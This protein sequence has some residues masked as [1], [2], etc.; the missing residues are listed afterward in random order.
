M[1]AGC[2]G[3]GYCGVGGADTIKHQQLTQQAKSWRA[4]VFVG[5]THELANLVVYVALR[6]SNYV[7]WCCALSGVDGGSKQCDVMCETT[8]FD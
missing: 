4:Q 6:V 2:G 3:G 8:R 7:W 5:L 1:L